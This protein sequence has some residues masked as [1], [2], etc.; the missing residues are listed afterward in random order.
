[1][2][3]LALETPNEFYLKAISGKLKGTVFRLS[4]NETKNANTKEK[5]R[6]N[7]SLPSLYFSCFLPKME[8]KK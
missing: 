5:N 4:S 2:T 6:Q 8:F 7:T 1:M 3:A